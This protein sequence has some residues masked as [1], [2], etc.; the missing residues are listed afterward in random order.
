MPNEPELQARCEAALRAWIKT[1]RL[2]FPP[3]VITTALEVVFEEREAAE[4]DSGLQLEFVAERCDEE[5]WR[6]TS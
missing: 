5:S 2:G 6:I 4:R 3:H 1:Q